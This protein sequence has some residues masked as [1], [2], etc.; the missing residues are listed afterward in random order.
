MD[1]FDFS[2]QPSID[3]R[4]IDELATMRC[5][6]NGVAISTYFLWQRRVPLFVLA[7]VLCGRDEPGPARK[8]PTA[9]ALACSHDV[10]N[11]LIP[12][13]RHRVRI[14]PDAVLLYTIR[15]DGYV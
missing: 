8:Y 14:P 1:D 9:A 10:Q 5:L 12:V 2:F 4:Q 13:T 7:D 3:K 11:K 15:F 6:E